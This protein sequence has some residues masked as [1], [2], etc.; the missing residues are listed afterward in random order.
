[1]KIFLYF[2]SSFSSLYLFLFSLSLRLHCSC[3]GHKNQKDTICAMDDALST[4][5][6]WRISR[7]YLWILTM[8]T[9]RMSEWV[10]RWVLSTHIATA[11][12]V[13][14]LYV[15]NI[16]WNWVNY[17]FTALWWSSNILL[18]TESTHN[19]IN[20]FIK[21]ALVS[22][23]ETMLMNVC[24]CVCLYV[25]SLASHCEVC[26]RVCRACPATRYT[27][28]KQ[29]CIQQQN[30]IVIRRINECVSKCT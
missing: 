3:P 11:I 28:W 4:S 10:S 20:V 23:N 27:I 6:A 17:T 12:C 18:R 5:R 15:C 14:T 25:G 2:S 30:A 8:S 1:M 16:E 9:E 24:V 21:Y 22:S 7:S 19:I 29:N 13:C 26:I